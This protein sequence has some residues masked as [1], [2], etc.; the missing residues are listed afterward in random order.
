[1]MESPADTCKQI[2]HDFFIRAGV[3]CDCAI[4]SMVVDGKRVDC[5]AREKGDALAA[6]RATP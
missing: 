2:N 3:P 4:T 5:T 1:M 6:G